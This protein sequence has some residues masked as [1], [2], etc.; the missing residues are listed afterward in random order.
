MLILVPSFIVKVVPFGTTTFPFICIYPLHSSSFVIIYSFVPTTVTA[1][2]LI[3]TGIFIGLFTTLSIV[4]IK[5]ILAELSPIFKKKGSIMNFKLSFLVIVPETLL[6]FSQLLSEETVQETF[7]SP[8][9]SRIKLP[10]FISTKVLIFPKLI[11]VESTTIRV[12]SG[13]FCLQFESNPNVIIS[14]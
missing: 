4:G 6:N 9:L 12:G 8:T 11:P 14:K 1:E 13:S 3:F 7:P 10:F 2:L 5:I